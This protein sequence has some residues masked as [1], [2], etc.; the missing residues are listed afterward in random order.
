[1]YSKI[2]LKNARKRISHIIDLF[3]DAV[4]KTMGPGGENALIVNGAGRTII[5]KD[6]VTVANSIKPGDKE[7][8]MITDV[9]KQ[10]ADKTNRE[11]GDG[12][13]TS[14]VLTRAIFKKGLKLIESGHNV[15]EVKNQLNAA[16]KKLIEVI[17]ESIRQSIPKEQTLDT[18]RHIAKISL[19]GDEEMAELV[20]N[21]VFTAGDTGI[22]KIQDSD[23]HEDK[24]DK[25]D[26]LQ[27]KAGY[28]NPFFANKRDESKVI[29]ENCY[30]F[31]TSH[32]LTSAAQLGQLEGALGPLVKKGAPLLVIASECGEGFLAN[33]MANHKAS[34]LKNCPIRAP[35]W[36]MIRKE[37]YTD[38]AALTGA[39]VIEV[40]EG[41]ELDK[42]TADHFGFAKRVEVDAL[43]TTIINGKPKEG[44]LEHRLAQLTEQQEKLDPNPDK[45]LDKVR[46]RLA[47]LSGG[48]HMIKVGQ[49]SDIESEE[50]KYRI[51]DAV[52]ACKAALA[53]GY[54]PGGGA[55]LIHASTILGDSTVPGEK[56]LYEAIK[57]PTETIAK[58]AGHSG[59]VAVRDVMD[60]DNYLYAYDAVA[61]KVVPAYSS[62]I[63]D[64]AKVTKSA[65]SNAVSVAST[66]LTTN[67]IVSPIVDSA[68]DTRA[69]YEMFGM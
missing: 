26:G 30:I 54:V 2:E 7:L 39:T 46:E 69:Q 25:E 55:T 1:M 36:G 21:A 16:K 60:K 37:F 8:D 50:R 4:E 43:N 49:T 34:Q 31:I 68:K 62:G 53:E 9:L 56:L 42:V 32:K 51:E 13:T 15:V 57:V 41:M 28:L 6:G 63:I 38:L 14:T 67:V 11:A 33:L 19:N 24:L 64:P 45:D 65:L 20:A 52:N 35:Y 5:T 3:A 10:A 59:E 27:F 40:E 44:I 29:F 48:V 17:D 12:T 47:K 66:L 22:V 58:N 18:L 61:N 23:T